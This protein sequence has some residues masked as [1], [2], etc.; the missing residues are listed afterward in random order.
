MIT[1]VMVRRTRSNIREYWG[2]DIKFPERKGPFRV[3]YDIDKV[4]PGGL[5]KNLSN[6]IENLKFARY[7]IGSY[8]K[9]T[10]K[11][12]PDELQRLKVAGKNLR[13]LMKIILFRRLESSIQAFRETADWMQKSN[14]VFLQALSDNK[15]LA[16]EE[17]ERIIDELKAG[18]DIEN[19]E[20]LE[21]KYDANWFEKEQLE[22]DIDKDKNIFEEMYNSVKNL[23][24][25]NDDKLIHLISLLNSEEIKGKK[26]IIF[27]QFSATAKY[28]GKELKDEFKNVDY[29]SQDTGQV[30][31][32]AKKFAPKANKY[33]VKPG[34]EINILVSTELLSEGLNLQDGQVVINYELHWNPVRII[35]RIGRIDRIGSGYDEI[36]VF[37][38]F[39]EEE[40]EANINVE[41]KVKGRIEEIIQKFGGDEKTISLDEETVKKKLFEVYTENR[42]SLEEEEF[43]SRASH[44]LMEWKKLKDKYPDEYKKALDLPWMVTCGLVNKKVNNVVAVFCKS[45]DYYKLLLADEIGKIIEKN[46]WKILE[47]LE[48]LP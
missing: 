21:A 23:T 43:R 20:I 4:Y 9:D 7:D 30:I 46:D 34:E 31:T 28:L 6:L 2:E 24:A 48:C 3:D 18:E 19:I 16:G 44:F 38:F 1:Q 17:A 26:T 45:D 29:V 36:Y 15:I 5:Y 47:L 22:K 14:V 35:Q 33:K 32:K 39:P 37:N 41:K 10:D 13:K 11:F 8:V 27:T 12:S 42:G 40:V 25:E